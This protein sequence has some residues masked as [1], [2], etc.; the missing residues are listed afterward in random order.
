MK[1]AISPLIIFLCSCP[2]RKTFKLNWPVFKELIWIGVPTTFVGTTGP[3]KVIG[4]T[5]KE[6]FCSHNYCWNSCSHNDCCNRGSD[7]GCWNSC[8]KKFYVSTT[9]VGTV[10]P[11]M[12]VVTAVPTIIVLTAYYWKSCDPTQLNQ[13]LPHKPLPHSYLS[14]QCQQSLSRSIWQWWTSSGKYNGTDQSW[15]C[16]LPAAK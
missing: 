16:H 3:T 2:P 7:K 4:K 8:Q 6:I 5:I 13:R 10:V 14:V 15:V 9:I 1:L 11:T 12:I